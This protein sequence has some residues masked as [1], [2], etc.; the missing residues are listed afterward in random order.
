MLMISNDCL[1]M[2]P[3]GCGH[4][5]LLIGYFQFQRTSAILSAHN[6]Q[7]FAG[8]QHVHQL[9]MDTDAFLPLDYA[10]QMQIHWIANTIVPP[11]ISLSGGDRIMVECIRRWSR[12]HKITVYGNE[13]AKQLC[14]WFELKGIE[15]VTWPAD[16]LKQYGRLFWCRAQCL[17][18][19][20]S[21]KAA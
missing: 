21:R 6:P 10:P 3:L 17:S 16:H 14:D 15:H 7:V 18:A 8:R 5:A 20:T 13:G 2:E 12:D 4:K 1:M 19:Q 11:P 9:P